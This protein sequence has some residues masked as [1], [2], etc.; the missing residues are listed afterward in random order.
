MPEIPFNPTN[1]S[2]HPTSEALN[3]TGTGFEGAAESQPTD[4]ALLARIG[5]GDAR[6]MGEIFDRYSS[7]VYAVA[8]RVLKEPGGAED[9]LQ[10][11]FLRIWRGPSL[12]VSRR[13][14]LGAWLVVA[15][16]NR[17]IDL[18][19]DRKPSDPVDD[20]VL[21][22]PFDVSVAAER[23]IAVDKV[24]TALLALPR[25]QQ[26]PMDMAFFEGL[27]YSEIAAR[28][29]DPLETV[30]SRIRMALTEI[31]KAMLA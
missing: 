9:V 25:E 21:A 20:V 14:S 31:R 2:S 5:D 28:T 11:V 29:S 6:A 18:L 27:T 8:L 13:G 24:K 30:K 26:G 23:N 4:A 10:D 3:Q 16:R 19:R 1:A 7:V 12:L 17:A 15:A 22:A